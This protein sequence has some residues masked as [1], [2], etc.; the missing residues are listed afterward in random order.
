MP[1]ALNIKNAEV[2]RLVEAV[3]ERTHASKTDAVRQALEAALDRLERPAT[4]GR[5][6]RARAFLERDVWPTL[7]TSGPGTA[8]GKEEREAILGYG[9]DG[10]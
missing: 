1:M 2:D 5:G 4:R 8:P 9:E 10:V 3:A 7:P 6:A